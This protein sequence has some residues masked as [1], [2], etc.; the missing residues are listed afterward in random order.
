MTVLELS[1][2]EWKKKTNLAREVIREECSRYKV[3]SE[4]FRLYRQA[5]DAN[6]SKPEATSLDR[7]AADTYHSPSSY[8][9]LERLRSQLHQINAGLAHR[10]NGT[11]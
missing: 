6:S 11:T 7:P 3:A 10:T 4:L 2:N 1:E 8:E 9:T 5:A